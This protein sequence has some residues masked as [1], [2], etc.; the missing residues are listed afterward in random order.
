MDSNKQKVAR[1]SVNATLEQYFSQWRR[2]FEQENDEFV[3]SVIQFAEQHEYA[4][5]VQHYAAQ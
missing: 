1:R 3:G 5:P 4:P 2:R